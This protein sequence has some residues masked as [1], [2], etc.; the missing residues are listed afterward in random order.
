M[1]GSSAVKS[2]LQRQAALKK[3]IDTLEQS[4][5]IESAIQSNGE[6]LEGN[7]TYLYYKDELKRAEEAFYKRKEYFENQITTAL[8]TFEEKKLFYETA[9]EKLKTK[10]DAPP[11][12][13]KQL[14]AEAELKELR[15]EFSTLCD[16][17]PDAVKYENDMKVKAAQ[18]LAKEKM[19][20]ALQKEEEKKQAALEAIRLKRDMERAAEDQRARERAEEAKKEVGAATVLPEIR[21]SPHLPPGGVENSQN[22]EATPTWKAKVTAAT[23]LEELEE[24]DNEYPEQSSDD[25]DFFDRKQYTLRTQSEFKNTINAPEKKT[26]NTSQD[27]PKESEAFKQLM[28]MSKESLN[29]EKGTQLFNTLESPLE[30]KKVMERL[31]ALNRP[32]SAALAQP[33]VA[34]LATPQPD[35]QAPIAASS[36][37]LKTTKIQAKQVGVRP[38]LPRLGFL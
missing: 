23:T 18:E 28:E 8:A 35:S 29:S 6:S 3:R 34:P 10:L 1:V 25:Q 30:M 31:H 37:I 12:T 24:L 4:L 14:K 36:Q 32:S 16:Q 9:I 2:A 20:A 17:L 19:R 33:K 15:E 11:K 5:R 27:I 21:D 13:K 26:Q 22:A 38:T 7:K